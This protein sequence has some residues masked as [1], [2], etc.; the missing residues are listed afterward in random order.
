M[1]RGLKKPQYV[2]GYVDRHGRPRYYLRR[3]GFKQVPLPGLP[4]SPEFMSAYE[5]AMGGETAPKVEIGTGRTNPGTINALVVTYYRSD[6]WNGL[7]PDTRKTRRRIIEAFRLKHGDKRVAMLHREHI[8][9]MLCEIEKPSVKRHWLKAVRGL[10]RSAIPTMRKDDPTAGIASIK[11]P[12]SK[13]HHCWDDDEIAQYRA[14]WPL[15]TQQRLVMEFALET[16]SRRGEVIRVGPQHVKK[17]RIRIERTHGSRDVNILMSSELQAAC[18]AMPKAHLTYIVTAYGKP[19]SK[20]G[21]GNDF[22]KWATEAGLPAR[23]RLHGLKKGG[24]RR[25]AEDGATTHELMAVSGHRTLSEVQRYTDDADRLRLADQA[26]AKKRGQSENAGVAKG[27]EVLAE[28][29]ELGSNV[30]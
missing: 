8:E 5:V 29:E 18:D 10:L 9:K 16:T 11:L 21:L 30:L 3:P 4:W 26:M 6:E 23:C 27:H 2:H 22:A 7:E 20:Y 28:G 15:G 13:G 24:M 17:G 12:K 19:R 25:L 14:H 1:G